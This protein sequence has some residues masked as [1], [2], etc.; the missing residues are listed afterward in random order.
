MAAPEW[1]GPEPRERRDRK[2]VRGQALLQPPTPTPSAG[3]LSILHPPPLPL[4]ERR[5]GLKAV[6]RGGRGMDT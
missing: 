2:G 1:V 4:G 5:L 3:L 6:L